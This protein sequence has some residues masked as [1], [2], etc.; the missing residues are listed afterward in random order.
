M[1]AWLTFTAG[2]FMVLFGI[3]TTARR[4][5]VPIKE[6]RRRRVGFAGGVLFVLVGAGI[7]LAALVRLELL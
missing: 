4:A 2:L 7:V 5:F 1:P 6:G 3:G